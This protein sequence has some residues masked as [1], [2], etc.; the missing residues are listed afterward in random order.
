MDKNDVLEYLRERLATAKLSREQI[1]KGDLK[2]LTNGRDDT[3]ESMAR[4]EREIEELP[5]LIEWIAGH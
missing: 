5:Q 1:V 3:P 4:L 2:T